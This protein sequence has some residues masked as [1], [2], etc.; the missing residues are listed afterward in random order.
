MIKVRLNLRKVAAIA[1]CLAVTAMFSGCDKDPKEEDNGGDVGKIEEPAMGNPYFG[2]TLNL[3]GQVYKR[4]DKIPPFTD[5]YEKWNGNI[6]QINMWHTWEGKGE[7]KNGQLSFQ[8]ANPFDD[9]EHLS[10]IPEIFEDPN[11]FFNILFGYED[12]KYTPSSGV[13]GYF[14]V[15]L[16][17]YY[18]EDDDWYDIAKIS[19]SAITSATTYMQINRQVIFI[20]VTQDVQITA[21]GKKDR[22]FS[23]MDIK[24]KTGWNAL[25]KR[26]VFPRN[27]D[28]PQI[29]QLG[30]PDLK[31]VIELD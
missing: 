3:S 15:T 6:S 5:P 29:M 11:E 12:I 28:V 18:G 23:D 25:Y 31:W 27:K 10:T 24:L 9:I 30:N 1:A 20:W 2:H 4:I 7:I 8:I 16:H 22:F 17:S 26:E 13:K 19:E 21:K 14:T